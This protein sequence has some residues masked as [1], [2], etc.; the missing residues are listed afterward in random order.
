[1]TVA[2][3]NGR[4]I[5]VA[6]VQMESKNGQIEANLKKARHFIDQ[7]AQKG[8][9]LIVLPEFMPTGYTFT[10]A[11][12]DAGEPKEGQTVKWLK[13]N[14]KRL[15]IYLGTSFLEADADDFFN[16]FVM[17][18]PDGNEAGR[19]RKQKPAI[20]EAF[21]TKG[22][23]NP[24]VIDTEIGKVGVGVCYENQFSFIPKIMHQTSVDL[25]LM[26][27]SAPT[28]E[29]SFLFPKK[30][31]ENFNEVLKKLAYHYASML[32]VPVILAN[33]CGKWQTPLLGLPSLSQNSSF[34]GLSTIAD[35]D[36][37]VKAQLGDEEGVIV[38]DVTIDPSRKISTQPQCYGK[39]SMKQ[40]WP[41]NLFGV[42]EVFGGL[43]YSLSFERRRRAREI[44]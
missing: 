21:F 3:V 33:K 44:S 2:V 37:A 27:H 43:Y 13:D 25:L 10:K 1:M 5:R 11:I 20:F 36:G 29:Q 9:E 19:V 15:G 39:K 28:P 26:P 14:S 18:D 30:Q 17:T 7:A 41:V 35:S 31:A 16:T 32:G 12:W 40:T 38:E 24:H 23:L 22:D 4:T 8:A 34:P 42:V 6:A